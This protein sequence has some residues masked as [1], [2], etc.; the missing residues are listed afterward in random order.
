MKAFKLLFML[1]LQCSLLIAITE[2]NTQSANDCFFYEQAYHLVTYDY[3]LN[4]LMTRIDEMVSTADALGCK[5]GKCNMD[6]PANRVQ[7]AI[8]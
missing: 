1:F 8:P 2:S 7:V 6:S 4:K 5:N 3:N